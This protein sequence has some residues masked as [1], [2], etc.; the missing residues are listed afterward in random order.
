MHDALHA[1]VV[2][3]LGDDEPR[4]AG[5]DAAAQR[6]LDVLGQVDGHDRRR[7]RHDLARLL[8]VQVE[9]AGEHPRLAGVELAAGERLLDQHLELLGRLA[10]VEVAAVRMP[11]SRRIAFDGALSSAMNGWKSA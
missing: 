6:G 5:G 11:I 7:G 2:L 3:V 1:V 4:V 10:L 9:D 8:L